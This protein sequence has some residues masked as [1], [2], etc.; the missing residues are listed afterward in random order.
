MKKKKRLHFK[1]KEFYNRL[2]PLAV[3]FVLYILVSLSF[4]LPL[5][6]LSSLSPFL[7]TPPLSPLPPFWQITLFHDKKEVLSIKKANAWQRFQELKPPLVWLPFTLGSEPCDRSSL[8]RVF[9]PF[10][11]GSCFVPQ[12]F[13]FFLGHEKRFL[14]EREREKDYVRERETAVSPRLIPFS[15]HSPCSR[16]FPSASHQ[17]KHTALLA[18]AGVN[19]SYYLYLSLDFSHFFLLKAVLYQD[20]F[21]CLPTPHGWPCFAFCS[22]KDMK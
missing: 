9:S 8:W 2:L 11:M 3:L 12:T 5:S 6:S 7:S 19:H 22:W 4:S 17:E 21:F 18:T 15:T 16:S 1:H 13:F 10:T 20:N 14:I